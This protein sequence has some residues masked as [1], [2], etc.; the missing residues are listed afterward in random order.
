[1]NK[2]SGTARTTPDLDDAI[3][4]PCWSHSALMMEKTVNAKI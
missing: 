4:K 1:M 3:S 2:A